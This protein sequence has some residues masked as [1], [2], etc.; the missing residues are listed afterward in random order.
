VGSGTYIRSIGYWLGQEFGLW[1]I[2]TSLRRISLG[3]WSL[4]SLNFDQEI[5][6]HLRGTEGMLRWEMIER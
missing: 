4:E 2:L 5:S 6:Y 3:E 1:G